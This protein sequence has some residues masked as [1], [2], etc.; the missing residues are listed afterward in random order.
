VHKNIRGLYKLPGLVVKRPFEGFYSIKH[1]EAGSYWF[2][3][4]NLLLFWISYSF[5][6]QYASILVNDINVDAINS[7]ADLLGI[8]AVFFLWCVGNWSITSLSDGKGTFREI[9]IT[10]ASALT[11]VL[12]I[13][14]PAAIVSNFL[15]LEES[16]FYHLAITISL[17]WA[18]FLLFTGTLTIHEYT[19]LKTAGVIF[20]TFIS[21]LIIIFLFVLTVTILQQVWVF[22]ISIYT[23][24]TFS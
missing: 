14:V 2:V 23:E 16:V 7:L 24:L 1:K 20:L 15:T 4:V 22:F 9:A 21:M 10:T 8:I 12:I 11:P 17:I 6:R 5:V 3:A 19:A 13:W 18:A